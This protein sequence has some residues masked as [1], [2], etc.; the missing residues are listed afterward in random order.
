MIK[1]CFYLLTLTILLINS[2][3]TAVSCSPTLRRHVEIIERLP[4]AKDLI[5]AIQK[6]GP[7]HIQANTTPLASK[8]GAYWDCDRRE[9]NISLGESRSDGS[10]IGSILFELHNAL[11][12]SQWNH[13][14]RLAMERKIDKFTYIK[15]AEY[16]EYQNSLNCAKLADKGIEMGFYPRGAR[17]N[18]YRNFDEHFYYQNISG[19]SQVFSRNYDSLSRC[20]G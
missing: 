14:D 2:P 15:E 4:E 5:T 18:T 19:H 11:V 13:L 7:I 16:L 12:V 3:L 10:I 6:E 9:I 17:L 1:N 8:F 20:Y